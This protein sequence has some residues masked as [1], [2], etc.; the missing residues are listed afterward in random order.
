[1]KVEVVSLEN[2]KVDTIDLKDEVFGI[3]FFRHDIVKSVVDWQLAKA[4]EGSRKTK[5]ISEVSGTTKKPFRQKGTGN[6]RQGSLR[7]VHMRG[8]AV[9]HGPRVRSHEFSLTKKVRKLALSHVL[10]SKLSDGKLIIVDSL[11]VKTHKT[12][13]LTKLLSNFSSKSVVM[14]YNELKDNNVLLASRNLHNVA[15]ISQLGANVYDMLKYDL[16]ICTVDAIH[17]IEARL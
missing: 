14:F 16:V 8:G 3:A 12:Q 9:S 2:K 7:S 4:R 11:D 10:S 5:N 1:M 6:A 17:Q 13:D 15:T